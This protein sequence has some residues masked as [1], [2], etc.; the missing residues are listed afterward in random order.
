MQCVSQRDW[1]CWYHFIVLFRVYYESFCSSS[2]HVEILLVVFCVWYGWL[3]FQLIFISEGMWW[4]K[5]CHFAEKH[6]NSILVDGNCLRILLFLEFQGIRREIAISLM[7]HLLSVIVFHIFPIYSP[8]F[9]IIFL[10]QILSF[11]SFPDKVQTQNFNSF[12]SFVLFS[13][14]TTSTWILP[15]KQFPLSSKNTLNFPDNCYATQKLKNFNVR[16][17]L[18]S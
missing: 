3:C 17:F 10:F 11:F 9:S 16:T 2:L 8:Q 13:T 4:C 14:F 18:I 1:K 7:T 5:F 15:I 6:E 12:F